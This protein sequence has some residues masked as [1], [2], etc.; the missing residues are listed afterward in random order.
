M[1]DDE[2]EERAG[3]VGRRPYE[4]A[5]RV[6]RRG[7]AWLWDHI[8][9]PDTDVI[10][11]GP[12]AYHALFYLTIVK[13]L[14]RVCL[15]CSVIGM[16]VIL[17]V[18]LT[19]ENGKQG[20]LAATVD[21]IRAGSARVWA[22]L[23]VEL[24]FVLI[25]HYVLEQTSQELLRQKYRFMRSTGNKNCTVFI[26]GLP[27][28][29]VAEQEASLQ[30]HLSELYPGREFVV[31]VV[32]EVSELMQLREEYDAACNELERARIEAEVTGREPLVR[33]PW[34]SLTRVSAIPILQRRVHQLKAAVA[35][36]NPATSPPNESSGYAFVTFDSEAHA[37][38]F[39]ADN[40]SQASRR[41]QTRTASSASLNTRSW[42]VVPA[43]EPA[44]LYW[45]NM[46]REGTL[47]YWGRFLLLNSI[48]IV[49][50]VFFTTPIAILSGLQ[51]LAKVPFLKASLAWVRSVTGSVGHIAFSVVPTLL[52]LVIA[53]SMPYLFYVSSELENHHTRSAKEVSALRKTYLFLVA[54]VVVMPGLVL[55]SLDALVEY[56]RS[57]EALVLKIGRMY[58]IDGGAFF[59]AFM[60][61]NVFIGNVFDL[62]RLPSKA[63]HWWRRRKAVTRFDHGAATRKS[64]FLY[65]VEYGLVLALFT[66]AITIGA[67]C[68]IILP[69]A[70][71]YFLFKYAV[72]KYLFLYDPEL[73]AGPDAFIGDTRILQIVKS[74]IVI[75]TMVSLFTLSCFSAL[76]QVYPAA[77]VSFVCFLST[78]GYHLYRFATSTSILVEYEY[79][80]EAIT[81]DLGVEPNWRVNAAMYRH[82]LLE[83]YYREHA[84]K[85]GVPDVATVSGDVDFE[86]W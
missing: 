26:S 77:I 69:V 61:T 20:F 23:V 52:L 73:M 34:F 66:M 32:P 45:K 24:V 70:T 12:G 54:N 19:G 46:G 57:P 53:T 29:S 74:R 39:V 81:T 42:A 85:G 7:A 31:Y 43:N 72:D 86:G 60:M 84:E 63:I 13:A 16:A 33:Y 15:L 22:L 47:E 3:L 79:I 82:P 1:A 41:L 67:S 75:A 38:H 48:L 83:Q 37:R 62:L 36:Q 44:D 30:A 68:V 2:E 35:Q 59:V 27:L 10:G 28:T 21:N 4:P 80:N 9:R 25:T 49:V 40:I 64:P 76:K 55:T 11:T 6:E 65:A 5:M 58:L 14:F 17:P 18:L 56:F 8:S 71:V 78:V 51:E 50:F